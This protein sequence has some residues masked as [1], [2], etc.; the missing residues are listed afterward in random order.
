GEGGAV[1]LAELGSGTTPAAESTHSPNEVSP[2]FSG[3]ENWLA[4]LKLDTIIYGVLG[5]FSALVLLRAT[6]SF[7]IV[8]R[9]K[10]AFS[11]SQF[12]H[13]DEFPLAESSRPALRVVPK[14]PPVELGNF[15][16][17]RRVAAPQISSRSDASFRDSYWPEVRAY[18][19]GLTG[20]MILTFAGIVAVFGLA[21]VAIVYVKLAN[22][23]TGH[24]LQRATVTA[25]NISDS[26][27]AYLLAKDS[28][29]LR[30]LLRRHASKPGVAYALVE[31]RAGAILAD[32]FS[33]IPE[34]I[35]KR[36]PDGGEPSY[37]QRTL[38]VGAG[39][40]YETTAPVLEGRRG[41]VRLGIWKDDVDA[42]IEQTVL[43]IIKLMLIV[44]S[45]GIFAAIIL[46]WNIGRPIL[47]LVRNARR[48]SHG[49]LD[50]P[51][52]GVQDTSEFG[53]LSRALERMR[54]SVKAAL[55]RLS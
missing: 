3:G 53:E 6:L 29:K 36:Q 28:A 49:D 38:K 13:E 40:V 23:I 10:R 55:V 22:A 45:G 43:P 27:P 11:A 37:G 17:E 21:T 52:L 39:V 31:N 16:A 24:A 41:A 5:L 47:R 14:S 2:V 50:A 32:S 46:A 54:S 12:R 19:Q 25:V 4:S 48:I 8:V 42:E 20:K 26:A 33:V 18:W 34:E 1:S 51:S 15:P 30:E 7:F 9:E 44:I 35:Q